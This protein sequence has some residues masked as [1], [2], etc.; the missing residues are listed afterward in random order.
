MVAADEFPERLFRM[1]ERIKERSGFWVKSFK[2]KRELRAWIP[3]IQRVNNE[4]F[5]QVWGYYPIDEAEVQMIG[6]Q[7]LIVSDPRLDEGR[8]AGRRNRGFAFIFP[9]VAETLKV[10]SWPA[11]AIRL[12]KAAGQHSGGPSGCSETVLDC[13]P[14]TRASVRVRCSMRNSTILF[15]NV[16]RSTASLSRSWRRIS[17]ASA[18]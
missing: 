18:I 7:L 15:D 2:S 16:M 6:D 12:G 5:T 17:I 9:D 10:Y 11:M 14:S 13:C 3:D 8:D 1:V 4:A